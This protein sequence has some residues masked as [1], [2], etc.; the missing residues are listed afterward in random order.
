MANKSA[1]VSQFMF[2]SIVHAG[3]ITHVC[4][5]KIVKRVQVSEC[6]GPVSTPSILM[7]QLITM[8]T[9]SRG[10][11]VCEQCG[12]RYSRFRWVVVSSGRMPTGFGKQGLHIQKEL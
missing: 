7:H 4:V 3:A 9:V 6:Y 11:H 5:R 1:G 2:L 10:Q 12:K 8:G